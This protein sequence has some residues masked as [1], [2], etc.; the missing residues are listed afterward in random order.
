MGDGMG[1]RSNALSGGSAGSLSA[2]DGSEAPFLFESGVLGDAA[3]GSEGMIP[4][5]YRQRVGQYFL[6]IAEEAKT[7]DQRPRES[8]G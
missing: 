6:R 4:T 7:N 2:P 5:G 8:K 3:G 1:R